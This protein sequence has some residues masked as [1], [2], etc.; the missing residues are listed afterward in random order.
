MLT[1]IGAGR[2]NA[3]EYPRTFHIGFAQPSQEHVNEIHRRL[4]DDG[5]DVEEFWQ[6]FKRASYG[7]TDQI[8]GDDL[9]SIL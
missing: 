8:T 9:A 6:S 3:V 5:Y 4:V 7:G 2:S 1:L